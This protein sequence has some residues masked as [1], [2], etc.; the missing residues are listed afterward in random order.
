MTRDEILNA[1]PEELRLA[2]AEARG[3]T[4]VAVAGL[5]THLRPLALAGNHL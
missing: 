3:W 1:A 5:F 2:I 4:N